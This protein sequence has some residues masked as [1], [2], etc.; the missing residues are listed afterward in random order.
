[1]TWKTGGLQANNRFTQYN[2]DFYKCLKD[3]LTFEAYLRILPHQHEYMDQDGTYYA[4]TLLQDNLA[5]C[6]H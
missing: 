6:H 1:M 3:S 2:T 4:P 5:P